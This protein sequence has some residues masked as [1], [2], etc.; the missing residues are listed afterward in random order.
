MSNDIKE[1]ENKNEIIIKEE[2][3]EQ[4]KDENKDK[5]VMDYNKPDYKDETRTTFK[6][7]NYPIIKE[8]SIIK[9]KNNPSTRSYLTA[10]F[11]YKNNSIICIGGT[12]KSCEQYN[13]I[14]EYNLID[15]SWKNWNCNEQIELDLELSGHSSNLIKINKK[16]YIFIFG[17]FD[18]WKEEF[19]AQ[20]YLIDISNKYFE[21]INYFNNKEKNVELPSPRTYHSS[22]YDEEKQI[23]YIYGGTDMNINHSKNNNFQSVWAYYLEKNVWKKIEITNPNPLG[24]PRGHSSILFNN[25]LYIFGGVTLFKKFQNRLSIIDLNSKK[26]ENL[27]FNNQQNGQNGVIPKPL[28]FH[29]AVLLDKEK[30]L[31]HGGLDKNYN[32]V[33]DCYIVYF[34]DLK[35]E[36]ISIPLIPNL[37]GHKIVVNNNKTRLY[38]LGGM[39]NFKYVGDESL[40]YQF[41]EEGD[42]LFNKNEGQIEFQ[43]M[44][45]IL[46]IVLNKEEKIDEN[47]NSNIVD[48]NEENKRKKRVSVKNKNIRWKKLFYN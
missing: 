33:N 20:S 31:I 43:P 13:K 3:I 27:D 44:L 4:K 46:E 2:K 25:K 40:I 39:D 36:K 16:E 28:A 45:N 21:K 11:S 15:N 8:I 22:N 6:I 5:I 38:I 10:D 18:N 24:V 47:K 12:D 29:S 35:F 14:N 7:N 23:I 32:A 19:T 42:N 9:S 37:F 34:K 1:N 26:I 48:E 17:G 30:F 41:E